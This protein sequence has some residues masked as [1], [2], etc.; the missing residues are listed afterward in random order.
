MRRL[1]ELYKY[2]HV[3]ALGSE[4]FYI[5]VNVSPLVTL[6]SMSSKFVVRSAVFIRKI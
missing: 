2:V 1:G 4:L 6:S 3:G 5:Q